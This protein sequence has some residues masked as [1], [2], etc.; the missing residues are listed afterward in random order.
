MEKLFYTSKYDLNPIYKLSIVPPSILIFLN[1]I[2]SLHFYSEYY[3]D[4]F[5]IYCLEKCN[6]NI[7][8]SQK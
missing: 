7:D 1:Y 4:H 8:I 5:R 3:T 6:F 2:T